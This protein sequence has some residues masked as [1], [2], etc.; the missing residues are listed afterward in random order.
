MDI[1]FRLRRRLFSAIAL[2]LAPA[3]ASAQSVPPHLDILSATV[4]EVPPLNP[5]SVG[6]RVVIVAVTVAGAPPCS[7]SSPFGS[8]GVFV[9]A[10]LDPATG[11]ADPIF[12][13]LGVD[14]R[15]TAAC[16][17]A[18]GLFTSPAGPVTLTA[19]PGGSTVVSIRSTASKVPSIDFRWIAFA[20]D[21]DDLT[22][23]PASPEAGR[24][25]IIE[26]MIP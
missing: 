1:H 16:D 22:R 24:W 2:A 9:D 20:R 12:A 17:P 11:L 25:A 13:P 26:R 21:D 19:G 5:A 18:S 3:A 10:D 6:P 15:L 4:R 23:L 7:P 8:Y 14:A